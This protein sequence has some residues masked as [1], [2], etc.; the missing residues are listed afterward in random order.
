MT[1]KEKGVHIIQILVGIL[2]FIV[3]FCCI[4][5]VT[6]HPF[7]AHHDSGRQWQTDVWR[8]IVMVLVPCSCLDCCA[9]QW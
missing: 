6:P 2:G 8:W 9:L 7:T 5:I 4:M 1:Y 3:N